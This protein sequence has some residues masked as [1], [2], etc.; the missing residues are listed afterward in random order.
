MGLASDIFIL[1]ALG[2]LKSSKVTSKV[3]VQALLNVSF[4]LLHSTSLG[5][6]PILKCKQYVFLWVCKSAWRTYLFDLDVVL[7]Y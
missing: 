5:L 6:S 3:C 7:I 2:P 4:E 1:G